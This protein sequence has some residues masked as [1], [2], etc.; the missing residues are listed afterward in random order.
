MFQVLERSERDASDL[1]EP[2][3]S[4][5]INTTEEEIGNDQYKFSYEGQ[6]KFVEKNAEILT[7]GKDADLL[8]LGTDFHISCS[9]SPAQLV[10][11][12]KDSTLSSTN[13]SAQNMRDNSSYTAENVSSNHNIQFGDTNFYEDGIQ[14]NISAPIFSA[15]DVTAST[16]EMKIDP[17]AEFLACTKDNAIP[18]LKSNSTTT[19][20]AAWNNQQQPSYSRAHFDTLSSV[21][22]AKSKNFEN[23]FGDLLTSQGFQT[24]PKTM[25]SLGEMKRQ[26]EVK[27]L[28]PVKVKIKEWTNGKERNIRALL[29]SMNNILW[30]N[31]ENWIQ[32]SIGDLLTAQQVK[33]YY[34]K[35]CLVIHPDK[36]V[37]TEN[38]ALARAIFTELNDA[39]TAYENAGSPSI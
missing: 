10:N 23:A 24:S 33:K 20:R 7:A 22:G 19:S 27:E 14:H 36:Q 17:F 34:R 2:I 28:D 18:P 9:S 3:N 5:R 37:G 39:W 6:P 4:I 16:S 8:G 15:A 35:A 31:A 1:C 26:D 30:P 12:V 32:P 25:K 38:E 21:K 11:G 13:F 29:G